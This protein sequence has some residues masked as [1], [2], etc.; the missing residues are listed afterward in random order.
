MLTEMSPFTYY[1]IYTDRFLQRLLKYRLGKL[2]AWGVA[3]V[4]LRR[5]HY[6]KY[7]VCSMVNLRQKAQS[8]NVLRDPLKNFHQF[9]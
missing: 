4:H 7:R 9:P 1:L 8:A 2:R 3:L 6:V 5:S